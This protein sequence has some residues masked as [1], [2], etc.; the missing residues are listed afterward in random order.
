ML[1]QTRSLLKG[2]PKAGNKNSRNDGERWCYRERIATSFAKSTL[3]AVVNRR[4][5]KKQQMQ[6]SKKGVLAPANPRGRV[7][8]RSIDMPS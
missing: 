8:R 6:W 4:F 7:V 5:A 2:S 1:D 3:N